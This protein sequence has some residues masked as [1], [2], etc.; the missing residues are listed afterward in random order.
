MTAPRP[1]SPAT[2]AALQKAALDVYKA[3]PFLYKGKPLVRYHHRGGNL[4]SPESKGG[5][6]IYPWLTRA[7][8]RAEARAENY[9][10]HFYRDGEPERRMPW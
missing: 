9:V 4:Y 8:C 6:V 5:G 3:E 10:P 7:Q 1:T 2:K